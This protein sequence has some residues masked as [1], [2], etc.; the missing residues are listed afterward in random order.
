M[1]RM[2]RRR[3][4]NMSHEVSD[5]SRISLKSSYYIPTKKNVL[6]RLFNV[7]QPCYAMQ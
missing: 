1:D 7:L 6:E 2:G 3:K 5:T 4:C